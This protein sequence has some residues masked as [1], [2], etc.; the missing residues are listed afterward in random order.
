MKLTKSAL[1]MLENAYRSIF[2]RNSVNNI[3]TSGGGRTNKYYSYCNAIEFKWSS[4]C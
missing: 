1:G 4:E 3:L 2:M